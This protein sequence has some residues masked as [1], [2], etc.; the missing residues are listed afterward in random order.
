MNIAMVEDI[1]NAIWNAD[2]ASIKNLVAQGVDLNFNYS[3]EKHLK[4]KM[5][6]PTI[7]KTCT[8]SLSFF[9]EKPLKRF[10]KR[11]ERRGHRVKT[12]C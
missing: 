5:N 9:N 11:P 1:L 2:L 6:G 12:R 8:G 3:H 7:L 10:S 4:N